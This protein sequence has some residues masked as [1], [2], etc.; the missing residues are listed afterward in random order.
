MRAGQGRAGELVNTYV[1]LWRAA[2]CCRSHPLS[3]S[4]LIAP[5][6]HLRHINDENEHEKKNEIEQRGGYS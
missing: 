3:H 1:P 4:D 5:H 6:Q 2:S